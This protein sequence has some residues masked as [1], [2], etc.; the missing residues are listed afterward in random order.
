MTDMLIGA[1]VIAVHPCGVKPVMLLYK[2]GLWLVYR[3]GVRS[4]ASEEAARKCMQCMLD[5]RG[6]RPQVCRCD[7][8]GGV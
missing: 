6:R 8:Q 1:E 4:F 2:S 3:T 5:R 7:C